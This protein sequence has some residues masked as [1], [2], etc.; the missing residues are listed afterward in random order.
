[1]SKDKIENALNVLREL[2]P[3]YGGKTLD[4]VIQNLESTFKFLSGKK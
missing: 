3:E 2:Q 1:M 4:N